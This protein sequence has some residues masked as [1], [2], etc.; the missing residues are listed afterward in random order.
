MGSPSAGAYDPDGGRNDGSRTGNLNDYDREAVA[1]LTNERVR[2]LYDHY[3]S[4]GQI[5]K[6]PELAAQYRLNQ[7]EEQTGGKTVEVE[8]FD[9]FE[10][11]PAPGRPGWNKA[12]AEG[13]KFDGDALRSLSKTIGDDLQS[14][15][16]RRD[17]FRFLQTWPGPDGCGGDAGNHTNGSKMKVTSDRIRA[18]AEVQLTAVM[19]AMNGIMENL[20][21]TC[22]Q[23]EDGEQANVGM[24]KETW[25]V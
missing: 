21:A 18:A 2:Q 12:A 10:Q 8:N 5:E 9:G 11:K 25:R 7:R 17:G 16:G 1:D 6:H 14:L 20:R 3:R 13:F 15:T 24:V 23:V 22:D 19:D 4:S